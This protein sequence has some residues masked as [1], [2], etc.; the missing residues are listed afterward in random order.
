[1]SNLKELIEA[2]RLDK[3]DTLALLSDLVNTHLGWPKSSLFS[4]D[5]VDL[6]ESVVSHWYA[7]ENRRLAG[8]PVAYILGKKEFFN[9]ELMVSPD[10][11]IPRPE[12]ELLV[13]LGLNYL[14]PLRQP[15]ILDL[16]TGSGA[17]ALAIGHN[18]PQS[19]VV[20]VDISSKSLLVAQKNCALLQLSNRCEFILSDWFNQLDPYVN[21]FDLIVSNPPYIEPED[22]HL[23][24]GDL[25]FEPS[26]ALTDNQ[27]GL[28]AYRTII[29][30][31]PKYLK[32]GGM[33][34]LE[35][36]YNQSEPI[37]DLLKQYEFHGITAHQ[38]LAGIPRAVT[39]KLG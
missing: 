3:P 10:V 21:S 17:I 30:K 16:G 13:E 33:I 36:G 24:Q 22:L 20:A 19:K 34:A 28:G 2:S 29:G 25:R 15:K 31:A 4:K 9:I 23:K 37:C 35:H 11:L 18:L 12:T 5:D 27:D 14:N 26:H 8:E 6:S 7:F 32:R 39:A 1:M 38:D